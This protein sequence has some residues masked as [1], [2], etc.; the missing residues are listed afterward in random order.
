MV[1]R[2]GVTAGMRVLLPGAS[3]AVGS[4]L[5]QLLKRRKVEVT[6][7]TSAT[8]I[9]KIARLGAYRGLTR[10][11]DLGAHLGAESADFDR[12]RRRARLWH[13]AE[14]FA[15]RRALRNLWRYC[16]VGRQP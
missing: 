2:A 5:V 14:A 1:H 9:G 8:K 16:R 13:V 4:A 15:A 7:I 3:G 12:Q 11:A 10:D 6:A